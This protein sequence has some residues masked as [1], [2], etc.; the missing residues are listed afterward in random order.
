MTKSKMRS[1]E[2]VFDWLGQKQTSLKYNNGKGHTAHWTR[3]SNIPFKEERERKKRVQKQALL[4]SFV[5]TYQ[6][7]NTHMQ[8]R[9]HSRIMP[10]RFVYFYCGVRAKAPNVSSYNYVSLYSGYHQIK[11]LLRSSKLAS[12]LRFTM[13]LF[14]VFHRIIANSAFAARVELYLDFHHLGYTFWIIFCGV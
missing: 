13:M 4:S 2:E 5:Y 8:N 6:L 9:L 10:K 3:S 14:H 11:A 1:I 7:A 12:N